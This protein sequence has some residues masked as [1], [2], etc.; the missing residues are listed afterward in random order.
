[1]ISIIIPA[2]DEAG[3]IARAL[4]STGDDPGVERI[5][6]DGGSKDETPEIA[7]GA[8]ATVITSPRGRARQMN[9]GA[10]RARGGIFL[11]L[12]ADTLLPAGFSDQVLQ[13]L[14]RPKVAAGAFRLGIDG[15]SWK[16]RMIETVANW[17][18][19]FPGFPY[20]DQALFMRADVFRSVGGFPEQPIME[21]F[22]IVHRLRRKGNIAL[23][24][25]Q[26][27]TSARRWER[28][29]PLRSMILNQVIVGAYLAGIDHERLANLYFHR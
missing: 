7:A 3:S 23:T 11:F 2:V 22:E 14:A 27:T 26:V 12:H 20:G 16:L 25:T 15:D 13:V 5:V 24:E 18:S 28:L 29:G 17:R 8:G 6:V 1:V 10:N 19:R 4:E 9:L 21:D